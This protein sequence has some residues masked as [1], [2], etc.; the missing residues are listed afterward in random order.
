[1]NVTKTTKTEI[2]SEVISPSRL[3]E[4]EGGASIR[5]QASKRLCSSMT[6]KGEPCTQRCWNST[7][8]CLLHQPGYAASIGRKGGS[9]R[10]RYDSDKLTPFEAPTS[11]REQAS[12]LAQLQV[13]THRGLIDPKTASCISTLANAYLSALEMIEFGE[14]LKE[15]EKRLGV[16]NDPLERL[17]RDT[18]RGIM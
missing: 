4:G 14:K 16:S 10:A 11:A 2:E 7:E 3:A 5:K 15:L 6:K 13:E 12:I 17:S 1:M 18:E 8:K 9:R